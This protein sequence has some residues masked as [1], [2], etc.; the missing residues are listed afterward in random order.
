MQNDVTK[1]LNYLYFF[2]KKNK[3]IDCLLF[4]FIY[5]EMEY[6]FLFFF[7]R[8]S[9]EVFEQLEIANADQDVVAKV[10]FGIEEVLTPRI[11]E[12][13]N[14]VWKNV[15]KY[16]AEMD[17]NAIRAAM[18]KVRLLQAMD[19][20]RLRRLRNQRKSTLKRTN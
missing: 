12:T 6:I 19:E 20:L 4:L 16:T 10:F 11:E 15:L 1:H 7:F 8:I 17:E 9:N 14:T 2:F 3:A 18:K 13:I 5:T